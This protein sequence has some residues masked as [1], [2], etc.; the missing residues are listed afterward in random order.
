MKG[1]WGIEKLKD[2]TIM[3]FK[4]LFDKAT[5]LETNDLKNKIF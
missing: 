5:Q 2:L 3:Q 1:L 4:Y